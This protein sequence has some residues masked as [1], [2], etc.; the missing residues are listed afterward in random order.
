[1]KEHD[2]GIKNLAYENH[3]SNAHKLKIRLEKEH[4]GETEGIFDRVRKSLP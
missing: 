1:M 4:V 2:K 3:V